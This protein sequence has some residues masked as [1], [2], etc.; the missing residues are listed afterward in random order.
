MAVPRREIADPEKLALVASQNTS[1]ADWNICARHSNYF[2]TKKVEW[3]RRLTSF[4]GPKNITVTEGQFYVLCERPSMFNSS[5]NDLTSWLEEWWQTPFLI[6]TSVYTCSSSKY[7]I[8]NGIY[9][10]SRITIDENSAELKQLIKGRCYTVGNGLIYALAMH[11]IGLIKTLNFENALAEFI[12]K[13]EFNNL[14]QQVPLSW[15]TLYYGHPAQHIADFPWY[16]ICSGPHFA[17][18]RIVALLLPGADEAFPHMIHHN[19]VALTSY[20]SA[21]MPY[22]N[23]QIWDTLDDTFVGMPDIYGYLTA[24]CSI[25]SAWKWWVDNP[26]IIVEWLSCGFLRNLLSCSFLLYTNGSDNGNIVKSRLQTIWRTILDI[27]PIYILVPCVSFIIKDTPIRF[28]QLLHA[29]IPGLSQE[30]MSS[31][32]IT[33][34]PYLCFILTKRIIF[35]LNVLYEAFGLGKRTEKFHGSSI[36]GKLLIKLCERDL[37]IIRV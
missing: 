24:V 14:Y 35:R 10:H 17:D 23:K 21:M 12:S 4:K 13:H 8:T 27:V 25:R 32:R 34:H 31:M 22:F 29:K 26:Y 37:G 18:A 9:P 1:L 28:M 15:T 20:K 11:R 36:V 2:Y 19:V 30:L 7:G 16:Y 33:R 6:T 3:N 5:M